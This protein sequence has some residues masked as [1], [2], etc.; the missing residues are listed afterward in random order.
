MNV[1]STCVGWYIGR[2]VFTSKHIHIRTTAIKVPQGCLFE[3]IH[4]YVVN[5]HTTNTTT[6]V[7][8][9]IEHNVHHYR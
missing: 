5:L 2:Y 6:S 8:A 9:C 4:I 7:Y 1:G 3:D